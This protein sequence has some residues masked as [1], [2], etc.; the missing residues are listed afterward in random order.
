LLD[1]EKQGYIDIG[2]LDIYSVPVE[3]LAIL[4]PLLIELEAY[5][6]YLTK[7]EFLQSVLELYKSLTVT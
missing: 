7:E 4:K 6:Q 3:L 2:S 5:N 1:S